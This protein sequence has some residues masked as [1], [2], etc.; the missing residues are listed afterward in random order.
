[1]SCTTRNS[2]AA[3]LVDV[4]VGQERVLPEHVHPAHPADEHGA[5][6][7]GDGQALLWVEPA[8]PPGLL[9]A[10]AHRRGVDLLVIGVEQMSAC[11]A[12]RSARGST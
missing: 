1:M 11:S 3:H 12:T 6:D 4:R 9:E 7:L 5:D 2:S 8:D 10:G